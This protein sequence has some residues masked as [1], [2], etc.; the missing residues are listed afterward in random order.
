MIDVLIIF[1]AALIG[2]AYL[3]SFGGK[4]ASIH[5]QMPSASTPE[6]KRARREGLAVLCVMAFALIFVALRQNEGFQGISLAIPF[7]LGMLTFLIPYFKN[8]R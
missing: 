3:R 2:Y 7:A 6:G 5:A 1:L 4:G 8:K